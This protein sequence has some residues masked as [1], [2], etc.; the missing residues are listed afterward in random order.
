M[1]KLV[2]VVLRYRKSD[3]ATRAVAVVVKRSSLLRPTARPTALLSLN[4]ADDG[5]RNC[6]GSG[7]IRSHFHHP[8]MVCTLLCSFFMLR[9]VMLGTF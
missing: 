6:A 2:F 9:G 4:Q 1:A 3:P 5:A 8:I 7:S